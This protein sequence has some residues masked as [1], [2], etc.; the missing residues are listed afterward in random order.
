MNKEEIIKG[1]IQIKNKWFETKEDELDIALNVIDDL[2]VYINQ[3]ETNRDEAL[4]TTKELYEEGVEWHWDN[5]SLEMYVLDLLSILE[6][7][8]E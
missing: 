7:G 6:R 1:K 5:G 8:K 4:K 2:I 3:L